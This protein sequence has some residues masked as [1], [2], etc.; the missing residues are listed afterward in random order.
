MAKHLP[1]VLLAVAALVALAAADPAPPRE[2][3]DVHAVERRGLRHFFKEAK[4]KMRHFGGNMIKLKGCLRRMPGLPRTALHIAENCALSAFGGVPAVA[5]CVA[6]SGAVP[7]ARATSHLV[8][9]MG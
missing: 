1:V 6:V 8:V 3:G 2:G 7:A 4:G 9:C 5:A